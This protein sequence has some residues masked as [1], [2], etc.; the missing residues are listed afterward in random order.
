MQRA[1]LCRRPLPAV[2]VRF[3]VPQAGRGLVSEIFVHRA[4]AGVPHR[5]ALAVVEER[6]A[7][8]REPLVLPVFRFTYMYGIPVGELNAGSNRVPRS[9]ARRRSRESPVI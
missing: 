6:R 7:V 3:A 4:N 2:H 8:E 9:S 1:E 5:L